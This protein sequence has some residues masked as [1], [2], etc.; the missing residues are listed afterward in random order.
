ME[1][2]CDISADLTPIHAPMIARRRSGLRSAH[3]MAQ[4]QRGSPKCCPAFL[5]TAMRIV[6]W[7]DGAGGR[8]KAW[9]VRHFVN[10]SFTI[11]KTSRMEN[12][13]TRLSPMAAFNG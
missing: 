7:E 2:V 13:P 4:T 3:A 12:F 5:Q 6:S 8:R 11:R 1:E 9:R 10:G